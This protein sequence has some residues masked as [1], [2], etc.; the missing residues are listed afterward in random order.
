MADA[1]RACGVDRHAFTSLP[2][3]AVVG[4]LDAVVDGA[5]FEGLLDDEAGVCRYK[6]A[7]SS[8][9]RAGVGIRRT[10]CA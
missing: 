3:R 1:C 9:I 5:C 8:G 10:S 6:L 4:M 2:F 7:G